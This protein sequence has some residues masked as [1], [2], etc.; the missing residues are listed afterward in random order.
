M[1]GRWKGRH[2]WMNDDE[3]GNEFDQSALHEC[4]ELSQ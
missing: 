3:R 1:R 2:D 4:L